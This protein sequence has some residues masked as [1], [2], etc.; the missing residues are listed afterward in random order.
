MRERLAG[1]ALHRERDL[2]TIQPGKLADM[3]LLQGNPLQN[4]RA[5]R[6]IRLV[7][8]GGRVY[9]PK[10]VLAK[11]RDATAARKSTRRSIP[12]PSATDLRSTR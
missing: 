9:E 2:G 10:A 11:A 5:T 7:L 4:I 1:L 12:M 3:A 8:L 6:S